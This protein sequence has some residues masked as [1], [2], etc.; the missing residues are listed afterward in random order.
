VRVVLPYSA[1]RIRGDASV[2]LLSFVALGLPIGLIGVAWPAMR[3]ALD[4]PA[5]GLGLLLSALTLAQAG[6]S[7]LAGAVHQRIGTRL[8]LVGSTLGA[9]VSLGIVGSSGSWEVALAGALLVGATV[10]FLDVS[11]NAYGALTQ[12]IRYLGALHGAWAVGAAL[13]PPIVGLAIV[14][15]GSWRVGFF[16]LAGCFLLAGAGLARTGLP[17]ATVTHKTSDAQA[18]IGTVLLGRL[19]FFL[20]VGI[21]VGAGSWSFVRLTDGGV[22][23]AAAGA[24][25]T[26]YWAMLA[27][28][29]IG[30][31]VW[32]D[33][34]SAETLLDVALV[35]T[36]AAGV[37]V[38]LLPI[39][40]SAF[41]ALP[42]LGFA[43]GAIVPLLVFV[44]PYRVGRASASTVVGFQFAAAM[45]GGATI[46]VAIGYL[47][48]L[49]GSSTLGP[50]VA[51]LSVGLTATHLAARGSGASDSDAKD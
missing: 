50:A 18:K 35:G 30:L 31:A 7:A 26:G 9:A 42:L 3:A 47:M 33:R 32:G 4:A 2:V 20:Y 48:E 29:R 37:A 39:G 15:G 41:V 46:P 16:I 27:L 28:A 8:M 11:V 44:T 40:V 10:G 24:A 17:S 45:L 23:V 1:P 34:A 6:S 22:A 51:V 38:W 5:T 19:M 49:G 14:A 25:V 12:G 43:L 36:G 13:G 21:E